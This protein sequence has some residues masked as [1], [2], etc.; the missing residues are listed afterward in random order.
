VSKNMLI[1]S[2]KLHAFKILAPKLE[3][4]PHLSYGPQNKP[5]ESVLR[6]QGNNFA[7]TNNQL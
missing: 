5:G 3:T 4:L 7:V 2:A 6:V 1:F